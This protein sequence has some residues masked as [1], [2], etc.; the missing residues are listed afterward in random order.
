M[1]AVFDARVSTSIS[2]ESRNSMIAATDAPTP[3]EGRYAPGV[4][5]RLLPSVAGV[6]RAAQGISFREIGALTLIR[7]ITDKKG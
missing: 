7:A 1:D 4:D 2:E 3:R 5:D 6:V